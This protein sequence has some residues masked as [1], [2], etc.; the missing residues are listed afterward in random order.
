M[1]GE[2]VLTFT[3]TADY[4]KRDSYSIT[5]VAESG[6]GNGLRTSRLN[7]TVKV[8]N[9]ED[10]GTVELSQREP[11]IGRAVIATVNDPDGGVTITEWSVVQRRNPLHR[12][13]Y[14][15]DGRRL[16]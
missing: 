12:G 13:R 15:K 4:E 8:T 5:I 1:T 16:G 7:V 9:E 3:G 2:G 10:D 14:R 6:L 11:Q